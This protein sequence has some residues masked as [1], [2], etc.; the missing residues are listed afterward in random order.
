MGSQTSYLAVSTR[1]NSLRREAYIW[2]LAEGYDHHVGVRRSAVLETASLPFCFRV[3]V[4][5][6][7]KRVGT[8]TLV[9]GILWQS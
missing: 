9:A 3:P 8:F 6:L 7:A 2:G 1:R 5:A 4:P